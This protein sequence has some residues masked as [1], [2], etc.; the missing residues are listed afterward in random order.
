[1]HL[2]RYL[3]TVRIAIFF[4]YHYT[5]TGSHSL[6]QFDKY[7]FVTGILSI[8][9]SFSISAQPVFKEE[10]PGPN[11]THTYIASVVFRIFCTNSVTREEMEGMSVET[12]TRVRTY[13][14]L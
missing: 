3:R 12:L 2:I 13:C 4:I 11:G 10:N 6:F 14:F 8:L 7:S 5:L 1:M 9:I